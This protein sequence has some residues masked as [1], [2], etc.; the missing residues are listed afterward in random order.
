MGRRY[1]RLILEHRDVSKPADPLKNLISFILCK[2]IGRPRTSMEALTKYLGR[3]PN[4]KAF[5]KALK[6][7]A[8]KNQ[9]FWRRVAVR[10]GWGQS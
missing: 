6:A 4:S 7:P 8:S 3:K 9:T 5:A 1:R 2:I 10:M